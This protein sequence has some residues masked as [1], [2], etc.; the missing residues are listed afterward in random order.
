M[1]PLR[2]GTKVQVVFKQATRQLL[3]QV[4]WPLRQPKVLRRCFPSSSHQ[5]LLH[6]HIRL[7]LLLV[8]GDQLL[9]ALLSS[10]VSSYS[11]HFDHAPFK[12]IAA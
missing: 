9:T 10:T 1:L 8:D 12:G 11:T 6:F 4:E 2:L 5:T 7:A 3:L